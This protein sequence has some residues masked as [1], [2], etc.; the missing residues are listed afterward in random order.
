MIR[1]YGLKEKLHP[2]RA[3]LS[4][5][6]N[7]CMIDALSFPEGKRVHAF[8]PLDA[9]NFFYPE[10]RSENYTVIEITIMEG[11]EVSARKALVNLLFSKIEAEIGIKP[12]DI[13]I[14][15]AQSPAHDWGFRGMTGDKAL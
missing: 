11:R 3:K 8:F 14:S 10:G 9:E 12:N 15:I 2:I 1:V 5:V 4:N 6:M 13:E 7:Q